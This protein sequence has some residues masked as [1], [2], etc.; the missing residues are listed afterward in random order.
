[1][2]GLMYRLKAAWYV[3]TFIAWSAAEVDITQVPPGADDEHMIMQETLPKIYQ[4]V[5]PIAGRHFMSMVS[6]GQLLIK[7]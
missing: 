7:T 6:K 3:H 4:Q 2:L 5:T 1:M